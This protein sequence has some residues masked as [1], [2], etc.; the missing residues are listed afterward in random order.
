MPHSLGEDAR[1]QAIPLDK[2][3]NV[4]T[5][6]VSPEQ[7]ADVSTASLQ[8]QPG[9]VLL[10][11]NRC[12]DRILSREDLAYLGFVFASPKMLAD[13]VSKIA[14]DNDDEVY[15]IVCAV[16]FEQGELEAVI[17][18]LVDEHQPQPDHAEWLGE[19]S[20]RH[21]VLPVAFVPGG[22]VALRPD[23]AVVTFGWQT[24]EDAPVVNTSPQVNLTTRS[25]AA[26][27]FPQLAGIRPQRPEAALDCD[28]CEQWR[29]AASE[30]D[31][32]TGCPFCCYLG[33]CPPSA[34]EN[35]TQRPEAQ[36]SEPP[37]KR[38]SWQFWK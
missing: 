26:Q 21:R 28:K 35:L 37:L 3:P 27:H 18:M 6:V 32:D 11:V 9:D 23:G 14:F 24:A 13:E 5:C 25:L 22:L 20:K 1:Y 16:R 17:S 2:I 30:K 34:S 10:L 36:K 15:I 4:I 31:G 8:F 19:Y 29:A 12:V 7:T 38:S 33:W